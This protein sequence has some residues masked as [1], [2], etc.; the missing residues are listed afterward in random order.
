MTRFVLAMVVAL[1]AAT[2]AAAADIEAG[3]KK[4]AE[5]CAACHG[6]DGNSATADFPRIAGQ[7]A[8]YLEKAM[9]DYKTG[10]RKDPIMSGFANPLT[11][12]EIENLAAY[13]ASQRGLQHKY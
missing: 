10:A 2:P 1:A 6:P 8:D 11:A 3:R 12:A 9:R 5:V 13:F 7:Y 4:A